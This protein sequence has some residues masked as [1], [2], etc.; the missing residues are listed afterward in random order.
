MS[1]QFFNF[2]NSLFAII[3]LHIDIADLRYKSRMESAFRMK[4]LEY[5]DL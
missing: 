5:F 2:L 1:R 4:L 3:E